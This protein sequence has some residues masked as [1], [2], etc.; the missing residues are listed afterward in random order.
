M[1]IRV[2]CNAKGSIAQYV[3]KKKIVTLL[4]HCIECPNLLFFDILSFPPQKYPAKLVTCL[5]GFAAKNMTKIRVQ[6]EL[7]LQLAIWAS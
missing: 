6:R 5:D 4:L 7:V 3:K 2:P 1:S